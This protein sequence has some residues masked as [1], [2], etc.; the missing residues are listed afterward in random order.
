MANTGHSK[1][2]NNVVSR[3]VQSVGG[4]NDVFPSEQFFIAARDISAGEEIL[5]DYNW[6]GELG[7]ELK[8][9]R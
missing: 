6:H 5:I 8:R 9:S 7:L 4:S 2:D 3:F 1:K